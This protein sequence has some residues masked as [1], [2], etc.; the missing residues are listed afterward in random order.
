M[1]HPSEL[2]CK[3]AV[4]RMGQSALCVKSAVVNYQELMSFAHNKITSISSELTQQRINTIV[5]ILNEK[6]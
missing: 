6:I 1:L 2:L 4:K 3:M 5:A